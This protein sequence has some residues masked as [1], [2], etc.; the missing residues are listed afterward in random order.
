MKKTIKLFMVISIISALLVGCGE[1]SN[2]DGERRADVAFATSGQG[3]TFY[4]A[5][6]G[7][8]ALVSSEVEGLTVTAEVTQGVVENAR[9]MAS[10]QTE[11]GFNYGSTA[12]NISRGLAEFEGQAYDGLTAVANIHDGALNFVTLEDK[13]I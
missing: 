8:S 2:D 6:S 1:P 12:Y 5:G 9:L 13:G 7:I 11:M 3:G 10:G 4:V